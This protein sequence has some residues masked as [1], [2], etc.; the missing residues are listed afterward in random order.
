MPR[1]HFTEPL[2]R[3][4]EASLVRKL[5]EL[6]IGRPSTYAASSPCSRT[7]SRPPREPALRAR[8]PRP[9]GHGLSGAFFDQYVQPGFTANLE[10]Q[11]DDVAAGIRHWKQVLREFWDPFSGQVDEVK[12]RRVAEVID[13]LNE[14]LAPHLFPPRDDG[15]DPRTCPLCGNGRLSLKFGRFGAFVG[16]SN[17][18][19]SLY[20]AARC[21]GSGERGGGK[22]ARAR[23]RSG[24]A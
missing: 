20:P 15:A 14:L 1:Q 19:E 9:P 5:E 7:R 16:C 11:L 13:A 23:R 3:Y 4:T 12:E 10:D 2:P 22:G 24:Y 18:P 8:G 6:G 21:A 17:Y